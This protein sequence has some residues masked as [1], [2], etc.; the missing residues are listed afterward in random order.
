MDIGFGFLVTENRE[1]SFY[2]RYPTTSGYYVIFEKMTFD[3]LWW[4]LTRGILR[5]FQNISS[6]REIHKLSNGGTFQLPV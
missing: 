6:G 3:D 2:E 5:E 1:L 4:S